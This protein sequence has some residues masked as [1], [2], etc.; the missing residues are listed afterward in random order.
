MQTR[1]F[2]FGLGLTILALFV[3]PSPAADKAANARVDVKV[4][5]LDG[6]KEIIQQQKGKVVV[7]DLWA[8]T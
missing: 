8:N 5:K 2:G 3:Q 1:S 4:V 6:L 7:V